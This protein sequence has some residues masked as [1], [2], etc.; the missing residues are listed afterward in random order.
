MSW[1]SKLRQKLAGKENLFLIGVLL[2]ILISASPTYA[3]EK[4]QK[5][6][7]KKIYKNVTPPSAPTKPECTTDSDCGKMF[8]YHNCNAAVHVPNCIGGECTTVAHPVKDVLDS[9]L[10]K[11]REVASNVLRNKYGEK[12]FNKHFHF[13]KY[14][15][16]KREFTYISNYTQGKEKIAKPMDVDLSEV[17]KHTL[18]EARLSS[19]P[20]KIPINIYYNVSLTAINGE[21]YSLPFRVEWQV[22]NDELSK[23]NILFRN[24]SKKRIIS[25]E[26]AKEIA[27][28]NGISPSKVKLRFSAAGPDNIVWRIREGFGPDENQ[29]KKYRVGVILNAVSGKVVHHIMDTPPS[30]RTFGGMKGKGIIEKGIWSYWPY[31][32]IGGVVII[33]AI[34]ILYILRK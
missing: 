13:V 19:C 2:A 1:I 9:A 6:L 12:Y 29:C 31:F 14:N 21:N 26:K 4:I 34:L 18:K 7:P 8:I 5:P 33:A 10:S 3:Q 30:C 32:I 25:K 27:K 20:K 24:F 22:K 11:A 23:E 15:F 17:K 28:E 16:T